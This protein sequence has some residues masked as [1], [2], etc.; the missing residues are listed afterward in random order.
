MRKTMNNL[1]SNI[2][3]ISNLYPI[4][5]NNPINDKDFIAQIK[6]PFVLNNLKKNPLIVFT[7]EQDAIFHK[8]SGHCIY[9]FKD[10]YPWGSIIDED[11]IEKVVCKCE[12]KK[13][14][15]FYDCR[16]DLIES[17]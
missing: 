10:D 8:A 9:A 12:N 15:S 6:D 1:Y 13:C 14:E 2:I 5:E 3:F 4:K 16:S 7:K 11:G 17:K